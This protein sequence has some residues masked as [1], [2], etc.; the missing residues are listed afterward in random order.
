MKSNTALK[1]RSLKNVLDTL[2]VLS[3]G[4]ALGD[5]KKNVS[6]RP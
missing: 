3:P 6:K 4:T 1:C 5:Y 2:D